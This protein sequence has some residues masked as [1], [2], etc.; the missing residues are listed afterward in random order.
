MDEN[1]IPEYRAEP[2]VEGGVIA[3]GWFTIN[4]SSLQPLS[5]SCQSLQERK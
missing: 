1:N 5:Y 4:I 2:T 3:V